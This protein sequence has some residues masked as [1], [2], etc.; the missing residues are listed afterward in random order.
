[1]SNLSSINSH[2]KVRNYTEVF[3]VAA[4]TSSTVWCNNHKESRPKKD[5]RYVPYKSNPMRAR[6]LCHECVVKL[7]PDLADK[8]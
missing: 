3:V 2:G 4:H 7:A 6:W 1:M 8:L 5:G